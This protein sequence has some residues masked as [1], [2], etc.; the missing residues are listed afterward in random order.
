MRR[1][2]G[3]DD[4][5]EIETRYKYHNPNE[6]DER[7][8]PLNTGFQ[9]YACGL[10]LSFAAVLVLSGCSVVDSFKPEVIRI[11]DGEV[12]IKGWI[13]AKKSLFCVNIQ[14]KKHA[15]TVTLHS[16]NLVRPDGTKSSPDEWKDQT[17]RK[18]P[19][20]LSLGFGVGLGGGGDPRRH[21]RSRTPPSTLSD[22]PPP[23]R[24]RGKDA[25]HALSKDG[26]SSRR[27]VQCYT[28]EEGLQAASAGLRLRRGIIRC[29]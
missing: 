9:K 10:A 29:H 1:L 13:D 19:P 21:A 17:P 22:E 12:T 24:G 18:S 5:I 28:K 4:S 7:I 15:E 23:R 8:N 27:R 16:L 6:S 26:E 2:K 25:A 3:A 20:R 14:L 11:D